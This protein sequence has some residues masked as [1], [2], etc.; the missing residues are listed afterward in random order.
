MPLQTFRYAACGGSNAVLGFLVFTLSY[1]FI[2]DRKIVDLGFYALEPYSVSLLI[3]TTVVFIVGFALNKYIVFT[4]SN[5]RGRVQLFRYL[6]SF[7]LNFTINYVLLKVFVKL[8]HLDPV[9]AQVIVTVII[10]GISYVT[11]SYFTFKIKEVE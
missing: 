10:V 4:S 5:L 2:V 8:L 1:H 11:Q 6:L 7:L 3:S 9:L